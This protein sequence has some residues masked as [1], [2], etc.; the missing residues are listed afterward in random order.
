MHMFDIPM[1]LSHQYIKSSGYCTLLSF[2]YSLNFFAH[3][4]AL[5]QIGR[6]VQVHYPLARIEVEANG[7]RFLYDPRCLLPAPGKTAPEL[8]APT[9]MC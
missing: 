6:V 3:C 1:A 7:M 2:N 8:S 5:G 9:G 4:Q